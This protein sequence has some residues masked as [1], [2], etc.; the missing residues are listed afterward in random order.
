LQIQYDTARAKYVAKDID[1][2]V[3]ILRHEDITR[4]KMICDRMG[5]QVV[6]GE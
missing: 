6:D 2:G 3:R 5:W 4:L 1:S